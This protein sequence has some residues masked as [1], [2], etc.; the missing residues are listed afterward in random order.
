MINLKRQGVSEVNIC[1]NANI[2]NTRKSL[3][4]NFL[5]GDPLKGYLFSQMLP[6]AK[7]WEILEAKNYQPA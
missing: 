5:Q 2:I 3:E 4:K 7:Y 1:G 6:I